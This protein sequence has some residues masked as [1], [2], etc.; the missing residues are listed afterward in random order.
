MKF[1]VIVPVAAAF[2]TYGLVGMVGGS[3]PSEE[4]V[5]EVR[6]SATMTATPVP[7]WTP[8]AQPGI[9]RA[10]APGESYKAPPV[11]AIHALTQVSPEFEWDVIRIAYCESRWDETQVGAAGEEGA[12]QVMAR[13]WGDVPDDLPGQLAQA[14]NIIA[15]H[16]IDPWTTKAGCEGWSK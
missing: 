10:L 6:S 16:G 5:V 1:L 9:S 2:V 4:T 8:T 15:A 14:N 3:L 12:M 11:K 13:F 7:D